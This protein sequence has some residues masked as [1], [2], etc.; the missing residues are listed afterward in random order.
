MLLLTLRGTPTWYY[1]DEIGMQD[2]T[3]PPHLAHDPQGKQPHGYGRDPVRT[4]MQWDSG[5][6]AGFCAPGVTP[7]LPVAD[8]YQTYNVAAEQNDPRSFLMLTHT[9]LELRR[10]QPAL[11][12]CL[13]QSF[14]H[15][16]H[17]CFVYLRQHHDQRYLVV[18]NFS[19]QEQLVKLQG[20]GHIILS[21]HMDREG[22]LDLSEVHLRVNEGVLIEVGVL[23]P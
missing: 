11:T 23:S 1:G 10:S 4:P 6:N 14:E 18:L 13:Y 21:T 20:Q 5:P 3:I 19:A 17:T 16:K 22:S 12:I 8:D 2:V 9:L 15:D 7:W